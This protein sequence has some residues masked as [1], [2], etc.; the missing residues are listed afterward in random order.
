MPDNPLKKLRL[1]SYNEQSLGRQIPEGTG[2]WFLAEACARHVFITLEPNDIIP[3][4]IRKE[5]EK[6]KKAA[7]ISSTSRN[8]TRILEGQEAYAFLLS[9]ATG[10]LSI[11]RG[12]AHAKG[13]ITAGWEA[14]KKRNAVVPG[15]AQLM[16][17]LFADTKL[18][19]ETILSELH[20]YSEEPA[21]AARKLIGIRKN[22]G[23]KILI[24]GG[25]EQITINTFKVLGLQSSEIY[26]THTDASQ[27][28]T[29]V[30]EAMPVHSQKHMSAP[31]KIVSPEELTPEFLK[32]ID[33]IFVCSAMGND[34]DFEQKLIENWKN[35]CQGKT[36]LIHL[37]GVPEKRGL[38]E[39]AWEKVKGLPGFIDLEMIRAKHEQDVEANKK[40]FEKALNACENCAYTRNLGDGKKRPVTAF[41]GLSPEDYARRTS[42][43][44]IQE[45]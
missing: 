2:N 11:H 45:V 35:H 28:K 31:V 5:V 42:S 39:G 6:N 29:I 40:I 34:P 8:I 27:L 9:V 33:H 17:N 23:S 37:K 41:L 20:P 30:G 3:D 10:M 44:V 14:Y 13:K 16:D 38:T 26:L 36:S 1:I 43:Q 18:I 24:V 7:G 12:D 4:T 32:G 15:M 21:L 19:R 22:D 25:N